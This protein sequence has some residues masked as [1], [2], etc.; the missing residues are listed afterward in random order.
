MA[1]H[2]DRCLKCSGKAYIPAYARWNGGQ[3]EGR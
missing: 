1:T 2:D 3:W